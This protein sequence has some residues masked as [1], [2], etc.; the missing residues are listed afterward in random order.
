LHFCSKILFCLSFG[1]FLNGYNS[2][3]QEVKLVKNKTENT[4]YYVLK[5][6]KKIKH[7][8]YL[9]SDFNNKPI[10]KG[11]YKNNEPDSVWSTYSAAGAL[12]FTYNYNSKILELLEEEPIDNTV[13]YYLKRPVNSP[14]VDINHL[15]LYIGGNRSISKHISNNLNYPIGAARSGIMGTIVMQYTITKTGE[16]INFK[17]VQ[18]VEKSLDE[19]AIRVMELLPQRWLP[20]EADGKPIDMVSEYTIKFTLKTQ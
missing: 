5:S 14:K 8:E 15:P 9:S 20:A 6:N 7:G 10:V 17:I 4:S 19:E 2:N 3:G 13:K 16:A 18:S 11:F 1:L 12:L